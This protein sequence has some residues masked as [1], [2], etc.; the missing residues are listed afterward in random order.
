[1]DGF[2]S[3]TPARLIDAAE[4]VICHAS[5]FSEVTVRRI[6][7]RAGTPVS[8]ISYHFGSLEELGIAVATR[9][10]RRLNAARL[11]ELQ[12][13]LDRAQPGP[14]RIED[15]VSALI[16]PSIR[17]SLD[18]SSGYPVFDYFNR[19]RIMTARPERFAGFVSSVEHHRIFADHLH[20][21][22]PWFS[23]REIAWRINAALGI[24]SQI[25]QGRSRIELL[26]GAPLNQQD[27]EAVVR[28]AVR[29]AS[30]LFA[31]PAASAVTRTV[32]RRSRAVIRP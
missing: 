23:E 17:W 24:R 8:A 6:A 18:R 14:A 10:Y 12:R 7:A 19:M 1:M 26:T 30:A 5:G 9:L 32:E 31:R 4:H 25:T 3:D 15:L 2:Q 21:A 28:E 13:A 22:A 16:A 20:R 29:M 11:T 27:P